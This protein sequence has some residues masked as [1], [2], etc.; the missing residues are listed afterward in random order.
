MLADIAI[1]VG[2]QVISSDTGMKLE[3]VTLDM[4]GRAKK[5][6]ATKDSTTIVGGKGKKADISARIEQLKTLSQF[7]GVS[8][9]DKEKL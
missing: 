4:L 6:V 9:F 8:K 3:D 5:I 1:V 7:D 2:G